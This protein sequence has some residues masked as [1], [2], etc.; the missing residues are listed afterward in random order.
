MSK[1]ALIREIGIIVGLAVVVFVLLQTT[2]QSSPVLGSS[3]VPTLQES[4]QRLLINRLAYNFGEPERGDIITLHPPNQGLNVRPYIKRVI[5]LPGE[6][7]EIK[8]GVV[9]ITKPDGTHFVL[10][11]PYVKQAFTYSMSPVKVPAEE[12]FVLGDN[13][14]IS[15]DSHLFGTVPRENIIGK[16]W[17]SIWPPS[18]WGFAP[19]YTFPESER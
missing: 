18:T 5:G 8:S 11:E 7:V 14:N 16:A 2:I 12:Y 4:G 10:D 9:Y 1:K 6:T 19:N 17:M 3:M 15:E 13:R